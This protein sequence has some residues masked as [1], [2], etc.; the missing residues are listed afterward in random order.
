MAGKRFS[1]PGKIHQALELLNE[2][3]REKRE[4]LYDALEHQY[5]DLRHFV[6]ESSHTARSRISNV[7]QQARDAFRAGEQKFE[8]KTREAASEINGSAEEHPWIYLGTVAAGAFLL[9]LGLRGKN[10]HG[11]K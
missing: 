6:E 5:D 7:R 11:E 3:A 2:A 8:E 10:Q 4:E 1:E 9:G